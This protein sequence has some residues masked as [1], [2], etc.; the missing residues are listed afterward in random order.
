VR[1]DQGRAHA[2]DAFGAYILVRSSLAQPAMPEGGLGRRPTMHTGELSNGAMPSRAIN[3]PERKARVFILSD[4]RLYRDALLKGLTRLQAFE[5][6][7]VEDLSRVAVVRVIG[8]RPDAIILD[9]GAV[10]SL[11][12]A[13]LLGISLPMAKVVAFAVSE[14]DHLLIAC[15]EAGIAGYVGRDG[16]EEDLVAAV[17]C[18]LR[19]ELYCSKRIAGVLSRHVAILSAQSSRPDQH[20]CLTP[21]EH[22]V[23]NLVG[24]GM[25][26]KEIGRALRIGDATVKNHVHNIL[27]KLQVH[28]R[29]EAAAT[30]R[31]P[32]AARVEAAFVQT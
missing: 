25:S 32:A 11:A 2:G 23:L 31:R 6:L 19:G 7:G 9:I 5:M 1:D 3:L 12:I 24:E 8:L 27:E 29:G 10:E 18:A 28:R 20:T 15:A 22:Q 30:F 17:E 16:S 4:V 21:R 14:I 13:R 26:N